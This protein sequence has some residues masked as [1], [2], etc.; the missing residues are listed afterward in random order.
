MKHP[1]L[2]ILIE[3]VMLENIADH[4]PGIT[5]VGRVLDASGSGVCGTETVPV[6]NCCKHLVTWYLYH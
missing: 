3:A 6:E 4:R 1:N 2:C 5:G